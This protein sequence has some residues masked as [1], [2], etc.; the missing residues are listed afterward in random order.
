MPAKWCSDTIFNFCI[1][2]FYS[3]VRLCE[4]CA[5][6]GDPSMTEC[7][8]CR[9]AGS[10]LS[11]TIEPGKWVHGLCALWV[12]EVYSN[13]GSNFCFDLSQ[14]DPTRYKIKCRLCTKRNGAIVQCSYGRCAAGAHPYCG[15]RCRKGFTH[16]IVKNP[17]FPESLLWE[18]FCKQHANA[19]YEPVKP[20][21]H[22]GS[23]S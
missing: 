10:A 8:I 20:K 18:I 23:D 21:V 6:G 7:E 11:K 19:V 13:S 17:D 9:H 3:F 2:T 15:V 12:P 5:A 1:L 22:T 16:R 14:I 4:V